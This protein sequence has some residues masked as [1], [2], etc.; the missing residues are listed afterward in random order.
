M[1]RAREVVERPFATALAALPAGS[2]GTIKPKTSMTRSLIPAVLSPLMKLSMLVTN[3]MVRA[4]NFNACRVGG[5][6]VSNVVVLPSTSLMASLMSAC[7][8]TA[9]AINWV[10][11]LPKLFN[12]LSL[13]RSR[14]G[15]RPGVLGSSIICATSVAF[16][17]I[18]VYPPGGGTSVTIF[19]FPC[20]GRFTKLPV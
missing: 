15:V 13:F 20:S 8:N 9:L 4:K 16:T 17:S 5:L 2:P 10:R 12:G 18:M 6:S 14:R 7:F 1:M 3:G 11:S 19:T